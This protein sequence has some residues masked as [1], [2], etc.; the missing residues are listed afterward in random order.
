MKIESVK[1]ICLGMILLLIIGLFTNISFGNEI[2]S[3]DDEFT[4]NIHTKNIVDLD[5]ES[6]DTQITYDEAKTIAYSYDEAILEIQNIPSNWESHFCDEELNEI[7][8]SKELQNKKELKKSNFWGKNFWVIRFEFGKYYIDA[9]TGELLYFRNAG[10]RIKENRMNN[11]QLNTRMNDYMDLIRKDGI[12]ENAI[13]DGTKTALYNDEDGSL[14]TVEE[15][16]YHIK[17][18]SQSFNGIKTGNNIKVKIDEYGNIESMGV[19]YYINIDENTQ[20]TPILTKDEALSIVNQRF[21]TEV[22]E[23]N[24][25]IQ[26][27]SY[28][29]HFNKVVFSED[30]DGY[31]VWVVP[32]EGIGYIFIDAINGSIL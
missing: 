32:V 12:E 27:P 10:P 30:K 1:K 15:K 21:D 2:P 19:Q 24:L 5:I 22:N 31:L 25:E 14:T 29:T 6:T 16:C 18:I 8:Y 7:G 4:T 20:T 3:D 28:M 23:C 9:D 26:C 13:V 17:T 11:V